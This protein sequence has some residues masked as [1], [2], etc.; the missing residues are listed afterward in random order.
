MRYP[1]GHEVGV[2]SFAIHTL[3]ESIVATGAAS[4]ILSPFSYF[5]LYP[6]SYPSAGPFLLASV[7]STADIEIEGGILLTSLLLGV[8]GI[9]T[10]YLMAREFR[11]TSLFPLLVA[12][13]YAFAPR[14]LAFSLWQAS[15]RNIFMA[16]LPIFVWAL[17]KFCRQRSTKNLAVVLVSMTTLAASHHLVIVAVVMAGALL[18]SIVTLKTYQVLRRV[19]PALVM[20]GTRLGVMRWA[21]L[22]AALA[23]GV[24]FLFGT[25]VLT[26]YNRGE[27]ANGDS[28]QVELV[29]LAVSI[30]RSVG[31]AAPM[32]IIGLLYCPWTR[33]PDL[34][35]SF[36]VAGLVALV[37]TLLLRDYTGFYVLPFLSV[38]AAYG[39]LGMSTRLHS[40][41][42]LLR[43]VGAGIALAIVVTSGTILDYEIGQ[44][45][46]MSV[47]S[48][49]AATYVSSVD[50]GATVVCNEAVACSRIAAIGRLRILPPAAGSADDPSP[51]VLIFGFFDR[52]ELTQ[53]I[54]RAPAQ[55]LRFDSTLLWIVVGIDPVG[56]YVTVVQSPM[57]GIP[58]SL[59]ARYDPR[60]YFETTSGSG[61][62]YGNDGRSYRSILS[63][64]LHD[65]AYAIY[66]DGAET[67]W[68]I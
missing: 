52:S 68:W 46:P 36:A 47:T 28:L 11:R 65:G 6:A 16:L 38:F 41:E 57:S 58:P 14:F 20:K 40:R 21:A 17:L 25:N 18:F 31:L 13:V 44:N 50:G 27:L 23:V 53:R 45:P 67:L 48:Y 49:S 56:D 66:A 7:S 55:D 63:D 4:W 19:R 2:D 62:F 1:N 61:V 33:S 35:E 51:E 64:S 24:G 12:F 60:Y 59:S 29:N 42:R 34:P 39:L 30:T 22:G 37:P 43:R 5:G 26:Q 15:T 54:V 9:L 8:L 10:A 32:A 3:A